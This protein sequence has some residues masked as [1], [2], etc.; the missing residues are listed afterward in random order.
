MFIQYSGGFQAEFDIYEKKTFSFSHLF[1]D[2]LIYSVSISTV[3]HNSFI[4]LALAQFSWLV[5]D[6]KHITCTVIGISC[7]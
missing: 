6:H 3:N 1:D 4:F 5:C 7:E 2:A